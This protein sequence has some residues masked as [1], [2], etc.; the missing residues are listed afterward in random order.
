MDEPEFQELLF[1]MIHQHK[2]KMDVYFRIARK[3]GEIRS[4]I[5]LEM[6]SRLVFA[7]VRLLVKQW[8]MTHGGFDLRKKG[9]ELLETLEI[10]LSPVPTPVETK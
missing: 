2:E 3:N 8:G 7:P 9:T 10:V 5:S 1:Q 6:T 4:D